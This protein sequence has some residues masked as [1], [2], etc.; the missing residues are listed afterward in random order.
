MLDK[1]EGLGGFERRQDTGE[2]RRQHRFAGAGRA[3][4]QHVVSDITL[5]DCAVRFRWSGKGSRMAHFN[6]FP[7]MVGYSLVRF[8]RK[9]QAEGDSYRRQVAAAETFCRDQQISL[10]MSLH[11]NDIRKLGMSAFTG[12]HIVKGPIRKFLAGIEA[13][14]VKPGK[15]LLL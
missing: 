9:Q 15:A 1:T 10:D 13:G 12:S 8:S 5:A 2:P 4:H 14:T 6:F 3:D 11:E 7:D